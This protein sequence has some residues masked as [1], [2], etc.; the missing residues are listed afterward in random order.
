[1]VGPPSDTELTLVPPPPQK[2]KKKN[3][4]QNLQ[5]KQP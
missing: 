2:K 1:M 5:K 4:T 3:K